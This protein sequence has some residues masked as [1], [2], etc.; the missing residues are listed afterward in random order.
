MSYLELHHFLPH[1]NEIFASSYNDEPVAFILVEATPLGMTSASRQ[2]FSLLF[3]CER[4]EVM[5]Q[6]LYQLRHSIM[7]NFAIFMVPIA[8]Q[9]NGF[10]YQAVFN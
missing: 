5:P 7:G 8:R 2:P 1:L 4:A 10:I 6:S 9:A 3:F